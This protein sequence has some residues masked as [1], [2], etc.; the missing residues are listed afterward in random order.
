MTSKV[1]SP[2]LGRPPVMSTQERI[3]IIF[4]AAERLFGERGYERV[5]MADIAAEAG[6]SKKSLYVCFTDKRALLT[7]L[8]SA[9][10]IWANAIEK[11]D[12]EDPVQLLAMRLKLVADHVLS[13]RH[14]RLC[15][16][17]ISENAGLG[18]A[19]GIFYEM[20]FMAGRQS[21]IEAVRQIP[22][23]QRGA[24]LPDDQLAD[25]LF[26]GTLGRCLLEAL[27]TGKQA[28]LAEAHQLVDQLVQAL[29]LSEASP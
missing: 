16:V 13:E 2:R 25:V 9:S 21:L 28:D 7:A 10:D 20:A 6:M 3:K 29:F 18:V 11:A 17:A 26:G 5:T 1:S 8:V 19:S 15:R 12:G 24:K 4:D 23:S 27:V 14:I 22:A